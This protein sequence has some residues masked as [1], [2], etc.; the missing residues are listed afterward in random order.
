MPSHD[1]HLT[2]PLPPCDPS[3]STRAAL[4]P[5]LHFVAAPPFRAALP[6]CPAALSPSPP[7][8]ALPWA[9]LR[10]PLQ[11]SLQSDAAHTSA[12]RCL[13]MSLLHHP[14]LPPCQRLCATPPPFSLS[15]TTGHLK[16]PPR[17]LLLYLAPA[18]CLPLPLS[19]GCLKWAHSRHAAPPYSCGGMHRVLCP[20][21]PSPFFCPRPHF[22]RQAERQQFYTLFA[23]ISPYSSATAL[24]FSLQGRPA[25]PAPSPRSTLV[26]SFSDAPKHLPPAMLSSM[27]P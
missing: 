14:T 3:A 24:L 7:R 17:S 21:P 2:H 6:Q 18:H 16:P 5:P 25:A 19:P 12:R 23:P 20:R 15:S 22:F 4:H 27:R 10:L 1:W 26:H 9:A 8:R 13:S 11:C